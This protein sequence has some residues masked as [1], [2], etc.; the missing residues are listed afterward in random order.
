[1]RQSGL[2]LYVDGASR[3]HS[4]HP[5]TKLAY[6]LLAGVAAYCAPPGG[7][8]PGACF[9]AAN[10]AVGAASGV[11]PHIWRISWRMLLPLAVFMFPI[12]GLLLP[13]NQ[14]PLWQ[15]HGV[16][17]YQEGI[18]FAALVLLRLAAVFTAS[19]LFV[20]TTHPADFITSLEQAGWPPF[21]AYLVGGPLLMLPAMRERIRVIQAAQRSRG[22]D[23]DGSILKRIR[24]MGP[25]VFPLV[26]GAFSEIEQRAVALEL[27]GFNLPGKRNSLRTVPD[28]AVQRVL[29]WGMTAAA[30]LLL[31]GGLFY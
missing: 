3:L 20:F 25:L 4:S 1:M 11:L 9:L 7:W 23:S 24:S 5:C 30:V 16:V 29:R 26:L 28:N 14:T 2:T 31:V 21:A 22:L 6:V 27:R 18:C 12:H 15:V 10:L 17:L 13:A 19:L 8:G